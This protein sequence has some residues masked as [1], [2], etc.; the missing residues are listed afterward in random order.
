MVV[1]VLPTPPFWLH[2]AMMR[3]GPCPASF[4]GVGKPW[5]GRP[6]GPMGTSDPEAFP[7]LVFAVLSATVLPLPRARSILVGCSPIV[8]R[9]AAHAAHG[10]PPAP[11]R[12]H[13]R[14]PHQRA[15]PA[16]EPVSF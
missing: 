3:A 5:Y 10:R 7:D 12:G 15:A 16:S 2:S 14:L 6:V 13:R 11:A 4:G 8:Q 1:V 9:S